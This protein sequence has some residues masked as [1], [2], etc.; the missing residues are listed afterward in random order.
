MTTRPPPTAALACQ[1][2][3]ARYQPQAPAVLNQ[4]TLELPSA[5]WTCIVGPNGA[6]KSSLLM[7]LAGLMPLSSGEVSL[8]GRPLAHWPARD[9]AQTLAWLG[10]KQPN[11]DDLRV[12]DVVML[13]RIPHQSW[14]GAPSPADHAAVSSAMAQT[15]CTPWAERTFG[16]LS[17]GEQ[18]RVL[19]ARA[20]AVQAQ[21]LLMDEPLTNLDPPHQADW[22]TIVRT[23]VQ[24]GV[25]VISVL[26]ELPIALQA[27]ELV[28]MNQ[29]QVMHQ[30]P[31][32]AA[33]THQAL[34]AVFDQ[35]VTIVQVQGQWT[36]L[37]RLA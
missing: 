28:V 3:T 25:T 22:L 11:A 2:L 27:D 32:H 5:R 10:Q 9:K 35:R 17:G 31:T 30:G 12:L 13:G 1:Q 8:L 20:L 6:G 36:S 33:N 24:R 16:D 37:P 34:E 29:G 19:L 23:L 18:Q 26:H 14:L 7:A 15:Q 4:V 21:V